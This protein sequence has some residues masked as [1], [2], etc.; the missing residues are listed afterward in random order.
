MMIIVFVT[1]NPS[2]IEVSISYVFLQNNLR[3]NPYDIFKYF[4]TVVLINFSTSESEA[5]GISGYCT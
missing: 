4:K 5:T 3:E 1:G 2:G